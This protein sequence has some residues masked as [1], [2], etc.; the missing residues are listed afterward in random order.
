MGVPDGANAED[1]NTENTENTEEDPGTPADQVDQEIAATQVS[2]WWR[3]LF[4]FG[5]P[6]EHESGGGGTG[7]Q[8]MFTSPEELA[9]VIGKWEDERDA[10]QADQN[11]IAEAYWAIKNPAGDNMSQGQA[12]ASKTSLA[13]MWEHNNAMLEYANG[14]IDKLKSSHAQMATTEDAVRHSMNIIQA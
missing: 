3:S 11:Q 6:T 12:E 9:V 10:I 4:G 7:G 5:D 2:E 13:T 1:D 14:Y 8:Y